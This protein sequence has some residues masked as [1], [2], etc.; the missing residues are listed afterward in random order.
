MA[1]SR[2]RLSGRG[3]PIRQAVAWFGAVGIYGAAQGLS[4]WTA[5]RRPGHGTRPQYEQ[6]ER[7]AYAPPGAVFPAVWSG[8]N[9]TTA[10]SAW[11]IW[12]ACEPGAEIPARRESLAWWALAV[13]V[14]SGY[15]PL[16]FGSRRLWAATADA[17]VLFTVMTR[18]SLLARRVDQAAALLAMPEVAWTA[19]ATVL[20]TAVAA[21]TAGRRH[22][23]GG[24]RDEQFPSCGDDGL[25]PGRTRAIRP[26][27]MPPHV[28][29]LTG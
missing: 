20:S 27:K 29:D 19:F 9:L 13:A 24:P 17:A 16:A 15:T 2:D 5:Q 7:P 12:R 25:P 8:L 22:R 11:R 23:Q 14:R 10:T 18:Y 26:R 4:A 28:H 21:K 3:S 6:F 1:G